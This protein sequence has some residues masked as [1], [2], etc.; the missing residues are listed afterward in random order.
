MGCATVVVR[1]GAPQTHPEVSPAAAPPSWAAYSERT[2]SVTA[3]SGS[4][5]KVGEVAST[6]VDRVVVVREYPSPVFGSIPL[7]GAPS[8]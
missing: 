2:T 6:V 1:V 7:L 3:R 4:D 8:S 5:W